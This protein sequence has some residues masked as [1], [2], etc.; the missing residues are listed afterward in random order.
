MEKNT[1]KFIGQRI[2][3]I[4]KQKGLSQEQL[5]EMAGFHFSY[6]GGVERAEKN[7]TLLNLEKIAQALDVTIYD[8][9]LYGKHIRIDKS[10]KDIILN[11]INEKL[12]H[13]NTRELRKIQLLIN[14]LFQDK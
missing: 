13:T 4:R 9:F 10:E 8:L 1:L 2:R 14:E 3:E 12:A 5:G 7:I 11:Q 6:I